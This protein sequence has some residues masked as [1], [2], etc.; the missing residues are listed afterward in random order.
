MTGNN[1]AEQYPTVTWS[2]TGHTAK[3]V[4]VYAWGPGAER[5]SGVLD[6]TN[7]FGICVAPS[8]ELVFPPDNSALA[9]STAV[10]DDF[11]VIALPDTQKY[12]LSDAANQIFSGQTQW[13]KATG[14]R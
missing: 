14:P 7:F 6:N 1:G 9:A 11:V 4:P 3:N 10:A 12:T 8:V 5:I 2:T 13:I